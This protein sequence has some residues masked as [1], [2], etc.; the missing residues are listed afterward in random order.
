MSDRLKTIFLGG[1]AEP[2]ILYREKKHIPMQALYFAVSNPRT[3]A[4]K[5]ALSII[6]NHILNKSN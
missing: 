5:I 6:A 1:V 4:Y 2:K 3:K